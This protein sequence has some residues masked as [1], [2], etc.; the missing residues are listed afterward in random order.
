MCATR[1]I[2]HLLDRGRIWLAP[3]AGVNDPVFR[4]LCL[5]QGA[6]LTYTEMISAKGLMYGSDGSADLL[7]LAPGEA[8]CA[9]QLFGDDPRVITREALRIQEE[10]G[11]ALALLD[12]NMGCPVRKVVKNGEG[13]ALMRDPVLAQRIVSSLSEALDVPVTCKFRSGWDAEHI[14]AV[15][16]AKRMQEAGAS[17][18]AVHPRTTAQLYS[19]KSDWSILSRVKEAVDIPVIG[20]GDLFS[21]DDCERM[22]TTCCVDAVMVARG[23]QGNPWIFNGHQATAVDKCRMALRHER[24]LAAMMGERALGKLRKHMAWYLTGLPHA[25]SVRDQV[26]RIES[27]DELDSFICELEDRMQA[28]ERGE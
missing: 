21:H 25:T 16:F 27:I 20:S 23:A 22:F 8:S 18:I 1:D 7:T 28:L 19:G 14:C 2:K 5:E 10:W 13:S 9:V 4:G 26:M 17:A 6:A 11:D 15:D 24:G 12:V 3:M